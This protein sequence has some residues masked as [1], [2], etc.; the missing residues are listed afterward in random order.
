MTQP[1]RIA[2]IVGG[3]IL[4][5]RDVAAAKA[6]CQQYDLVPE[7]FVCNDKMIDWPEAAVAVTLHNHKVPRWLKARA[8]LGL[9]PHQE[10]WANIFNSHRGITHHAEDWRGS[11]G[12]F[13]VTV[14]RCKNHKKIVLCGV[15]MDTSQ[16]H[17]IRKKPWKNCPAFQPAWHGH[18]MEI[19]YYVR[20][21]SGYWTE[22]LLGKPSPEWLRDNCGPMLVRMVPLRT[23]EMI[24]K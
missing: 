17:Y 14:A 15:P 16:D 11:V 24:V 19:G 3:A 5:D 22:E 20:S 8:R 2:V 4:V 23:G 21:L 10:V 13:G 18:L 12:L 6:L 7:F 9:A 1:R